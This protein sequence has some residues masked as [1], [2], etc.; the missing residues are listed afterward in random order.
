[1]AEEYLPDNEKLW[2]RIHK[3]HFLQ[4]GRVSSAAFSDNQLSVDIASIQQDMS[5]T[6]SDGT[7]VVEF[8]CSIARELDQ[9]VVP[10]PLDDNPAHALVKG[11]KPKSTRRKLRDAARFRSR[12]L[13]LRDS[14]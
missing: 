3:T 2:R 8:E 4:D 1:L 6:L 9:Q 14:R 10:D 12:E 5:I 13:I 7:G 11:A